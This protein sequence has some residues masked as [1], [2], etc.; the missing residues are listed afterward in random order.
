MEHPRDCPHGGWV[1]GALRRQPKCLGNTD[2]ACIDR[3]K[4]YPMTP[5]YFGMP[6]EIQSFRRPSRASSRQQAAATSEADPLAWNG[7][8]FHTKT[9]AWNMDQYY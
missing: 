4:P 5:L 9:A 3:E 8:D 1:F 2:V 6:L 7:M